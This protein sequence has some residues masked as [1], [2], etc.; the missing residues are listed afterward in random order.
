ML[1][2]ALTGGI[3]SGKT[4][5]TDLFTQLAAQY[6]VTAQVNII[7]ADIIARQLLSGSL[8]SSPGAALL[9]VKSTF[10]LSVFDH[11]GSI[12]R[13]RLRALIFSDKEKKKQLE[14]LLHPLIYNDIHMQIQTLKQQYDKGLIIIAIP[15][16]VESNNT[17]PFDRIL[18]IDLPVELQM[19]RAGKRDQCSPDTIKQIIASQASRKTRL[20]AADD[21]IDNAGGK[22]QLR[23]KIKALF[24]FYLSL[25][26]ID[27]SH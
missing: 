22:E 11:S 26:K 20:Q 18:V 21:I 7:D 8:D 6:K 25:E 14:A 3:G 2:I 9:A 5:V 13:A 24:S 10:G 15:L 16:L 19:Q 1:S 17:Y 23:T 12:E 4:A 27:H